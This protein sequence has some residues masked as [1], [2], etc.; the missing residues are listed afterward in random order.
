MPG[1]QL[2]TLLPKAISKSALDPFLPLRTDLPVPDLN[3]L[4]CCELGSIAFRVL[5]DIA[6][7]S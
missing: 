2:L 4:H 5:P 1:V 3:L 7:E 6:D